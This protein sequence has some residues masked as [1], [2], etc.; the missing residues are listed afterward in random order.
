MS[1]PGSALR[2]AV[3]AA[4][5]AVLL[6]LPMLSVARADQRA[7]ARPAARTQLKKQ[8]QKQFAHKELDEVTTKPD[9][10]TWPYRNMA[11]PCW[12]T[13]PAGDPNYHGNNV[14]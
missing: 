3:V 12:S 7:E 11:P 8:K 9:G 13:W 1:K 2:D 4:I 5:V 14:R 10:C 6:S